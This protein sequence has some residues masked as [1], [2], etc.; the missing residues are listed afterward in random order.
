V[1]RRLVLLLIGA[2]G[3]VLLTVA[4]TA[5]LTGLDPE[6]NWGAARREVLAAGVGT[7]G[8]ALVAWLWTALGRA[9]SRTADSLRALDRRASQSRWVA[10]IRRACLWTLRGLRHAADA[11]GGAVGD[12]V[13]GS[14]LGRWASDR[15]ERAPRLAAG[16]VLCLAIPVAIWLVSV[17]RWTHWPDTGHYYDDLAQALRAGQLSLLEKPDP[18]L[19]ALSDPY[20]FEQR[21]HVSAPWD[22]VLFDGKFYLYWG[23][24]PALLLAAWKAL[25][26][27][28]VGDNV[29]VFVFVL[30]TVLFL[31]L[32]LAELWRSRY[33]DLTA[34]ALVPALLVGAFAYP[35]P[36]LLNRP[37]VYE[38][39]IAACQCFLSAGLFLAA[40]IL[41]D[42]QVHGWRLALAGACWACAMGSRATLVPAAVVWACLAAWAAVRSREGLPSGSVRVAS[43]VLVPVLLGCMALGWYNA[44]R[45]GSPFELGHRYQLTGMNLHAEYAQV[46][47]LGNLLINV[48]N[49]LISPPRVLAV[50]PYI[51]PNWGTVAVPLLTWLGLR[52]PGVAILNPRLYYAE[53]VTGVIYALPFAAFSIIALLRALP[54]TAPADVQ[55]PRAANAEVSWHPSGRTVA[56]ALILGTIL[57]MAPSLFFVVGTARYLADVVPTL[58]ILSSFGAWEWV[59]ARQRRGSSVGGVVLLIWGVALASVVISLL[60]ATTGYDMRFERLN[61]ELFD[62]IV[63]FFAL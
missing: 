26:P 43:A 40:P 44:A 11:V 58:V 33:R 21:R 4:V 5:H 7:L 54:R 22:V 56:I 16:V 48:R 13:R 50:F 30:G 49:Y 18:A 19:L 47:S 12:A 25:A 24:V 38:A 61:P 36:W 6:G 53:Q 55:A 41:L 37:A 39:S 62:R 2:V 57:A 17:G 14:A 34:W 35:L 29:L 20:D 51:K 1:T 52:F 9:A 15:P 45:F 28:V 31:L 42:G 46:F 3:L 23:P 59:S 63:R 10:P 32:S 27:M 8:V 60:L